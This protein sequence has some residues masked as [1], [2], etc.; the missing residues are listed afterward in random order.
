MQEDPAGRLLEYTDENGRI[1]GASYKME[2]SVDKDIKQSRKKWRRRRRRRRSIVVLMVVGG[3][4]GGEVWWFWGR[5]MRWGIK[6][7]ADKGQ[8]QKPGRTG[9]ARAE[10]EA[11]ATTTRQNRPGWKGR[12]IEFAPRPRTTLSLRS[13]HSVLTSWTHLA[14]PRQANP[15]TRQR[16]G[17]GKTDL[18][19]IGWAN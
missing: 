11:P 6:K 15:K 18:R 3:G 2:W 13:P 5:V 17:G 4:D 10:A 8:G 12:K 14:K 9:Q 16:Q 19:R 7:T 1:G